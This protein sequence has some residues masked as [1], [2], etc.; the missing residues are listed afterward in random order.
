VSHRRR[1]LCT[2]ELGPAYSWA[3]QEPGK[4]AALLRDAADSFERLAREHDAD[5]E[6]SRTGF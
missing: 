4:T 6:R 1:L 3:A 5:A 2:C